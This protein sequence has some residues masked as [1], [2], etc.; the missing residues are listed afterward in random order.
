MNTLKTEL[1]NPQVLAAL[2]LDPSFPYAKAEKVKFLAF[3]V[4]GILTDGG[5][6][7]DA[8]GLCMKRFDVQD[9]VAFKLAQNVGIVMALITGMESSAV[10]QRARALGIEECHSGIFDK[11][12]VMEELRKKHSLEWN[13]I[14][15]T[16]DDWLDIPLLRRVGL[17]MTVADAQ[18]EVRGL[19]DYVS[20]LGG[21][22]GAVRQ[23]VRHVLAAQ[24]KLEPQLRQWAS[25]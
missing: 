10:E 17:A 12:A 11:V 4:D 1:P 6:Y 18:P 14:A 25:V 3:D 23:L 21:G 24:G 16:G 9:G 5:L 2:E 22:R 20:P 19:V 15:Y 8:S 7:Y 13:E